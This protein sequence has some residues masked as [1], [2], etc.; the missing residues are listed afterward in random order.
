MST[1]V[2]VYIAEA[3]PAHLR[4]RLVAFQSVLITM[5]RFCGALASAVA[6]TLYPPVTGRKQPVLMM[7]TDLLTA[8]KAAGAHLSHSH[9][10]SPFR[11]QWLDVLNF[12]SRRSV[13]PFPPHRSLSYLRRPSNFDVL[14]RVSSVLFAFFFL[15]Y[16]HTHD[17]RAP[18]LFVH[19]HISTF[20]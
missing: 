1:T 16:T 13:P 17:T 14:P 10:Q 2:S 9:H 19:S 12:S 15:F 18:F 5:G 20:E 4:G 3:S 7:T 8:T 6:F 11:L